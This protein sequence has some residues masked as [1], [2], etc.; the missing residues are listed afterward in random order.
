MDRDHRADMALDHKLAEAHRLLNDILVALAGQRLSPGT[1]RAITT[2]ALC[3]SDER[4]RIS[5]RWD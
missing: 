4:H 1:L 2:A 5:Q 3:L